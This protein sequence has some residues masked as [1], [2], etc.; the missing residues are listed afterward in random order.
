MSSKV[1]QMIT[2]VL[3][4]SVGV[5]T[6]TVH[7]D[8]TDSEE[9]IITATIREETVISSPISNLELQEVLEGDGFGF[10]DDTTAIEDIKTITANGAELSILDNLEQALSLEVLVA[11]N[12]NI[13]SLEALSDLPDLE[14]VDVTNNNINVLNLAGFV[15]LKELHVKGNNISRVFSHSSGKSLISID[16]DELDLSNNDLGGEVVHLEEYSDSEAK[17]IILSHP[18]EGLA[19][20]T[21]LKSLNIS[22]NSNLAD[23]TGM[24]NLAEL[25]SLTVDLSQMTT[26]LNELKRVADNLP[27]P[28]QLTIFVIDNNLNEREFA[29]NVMNWEKTIGVSIIEAEGFIPKELLTGSLDYS[30]S[31]S[32]QDIEDVDIFEDLE[33]LDNLVDMEKLNSLDELENNFDEV[34]NSFVEHGLD[35]L[36]L[37]SSGN[38]VVVDDE[39]YED[40]VEEPAR[41]IEYSDIV[42]APIEDEFLT[43]KSIPEDTPLVRYEGSNSFTIIRALL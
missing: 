23:L 32:E 42:D 3:T 7:A 9:T 41:T 10:N 13:T 20:L 2:A 16:L 34:D 26:L 29:D 11:K 19:T 28:D 24:E 37:Y 21:Q 5:I 27:N 8:V 18:L 12:N 17:A 1:Q 25:T 30:M 35:E 33:R 38:L 36:L 22:G 15:S 4:V 40:E 43:E 31:E 6:P 39:D 14:V